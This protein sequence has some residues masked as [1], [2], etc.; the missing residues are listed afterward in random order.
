VIDSALGAARQFEP[1]GKP[2]ANLV[3]SRALIALEADDLQSALTAYQ[4]SI[5]RSRCRLQSEPQHRELGEQQPS[6][7]LCSTIAKSQCAQSAPEHP[8]EHCGDSRTDHP[9]STPL[10]EDSRE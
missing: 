1:N 3:K 9:G 5:L 2:H 4:Q 10:W 7:C 6:S 8:S